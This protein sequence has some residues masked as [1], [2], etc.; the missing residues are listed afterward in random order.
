MCACETDEKVRCWTQRSQKS[1]V[2]HW[3]H[4]LTGRSKGEEGGA[5]A[6]ST[7]TS[8]REPVR[9]GQ[10]PGKA[11][12]PGPVAGQLSACAVV[13]QR[14]ALPHLP[15]SAASHPQPPACPT[16]YSF[17]REYCFCSGLLKPSSPN[18][19]LCGALRQRRIKIG[20]FLINVSVIP[21]STFGRKVIFYHPSPK[22]Q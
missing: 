17:V 13:S 11:P 10:Q 12:S 4:C 6:A 21:H 14:C 22:S 16:N 1:G 15:A 7:V 18:T 20:L 8:A 19:L 3:Q 2:L 9:D 5:N